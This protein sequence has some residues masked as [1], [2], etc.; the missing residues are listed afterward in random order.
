MQIDMTKEVELSG[1]RKKALKNSQQS[2]EERTCILDMVC[3]VINSI[4]HANILLK[5]EEIKAQITQLH[6]PTNNFFVKNS[7][8]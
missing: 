5:Q 6:S 7:G 1:S 4:S 2:T 3:T 8:E